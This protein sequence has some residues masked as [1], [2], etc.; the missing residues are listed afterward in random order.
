MENTLSDVQK[1][2]LA[3]LKAMV[4][5][6]FLG[7]PIALDIDRISVSADWADGARTIAAQPDCPRNITA[8][9]T[10]ANNSITGGTLTIQGLDAQGRYVEETMTPDGAGGGKTLTGTKIFG[11]VTSAIITG[12]TGSIDGGVDVL[13]IGVG[14]VIGLPMD[15]A[16][17]VEVKHVYLDGARIA[18]PD[19]IPYGVS[20][21]GIDINAATYDGAKIMHAFVQPSG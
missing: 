15:I 10:D 7:A 1:N 4:E 17:V 6:V 18:A 13:V 8:A 5:P 19:A 3:Q 16:A 14:N 20:I 2:Q 21:S 12:T 11:Y 9:L